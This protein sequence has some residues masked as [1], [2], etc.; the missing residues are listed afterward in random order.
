MVGECSDNVF[1][2]RLWREN[3]TVGLTPWRGHIRHIRS[4]RHKYFRDLDEMERFMNEHSLAAAPEPDLKPR[5]HSAD[6]R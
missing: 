3:G 5:G 2:A 6:E 4:G 1:V